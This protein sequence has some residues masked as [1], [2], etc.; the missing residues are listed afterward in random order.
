MNPDSLRGGNTEDIE[1]QEQLW[2]QR[3]INIINYAV[4]VSDKILFYFEII[5]IYKDYRYIL[6][7][8]VLR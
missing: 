4:A 3:S 6:L 5:W 2:D 1:H 8:D 7:S